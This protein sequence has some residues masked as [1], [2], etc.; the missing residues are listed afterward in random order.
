MGIRIRNNDDNV[1][2][3]F[4]TNILDLVD[5]PHRPVGV[6]NVD[7][8]HVEANTTE[9][10]CKT[11]IIEE[12]DALL[13]C[14]WSVSAFYFILFYFIFRYGIPVNLNARPRGY[15]TCSVEPGTLA[16]L[17]DNLHHH[18][19][20]VRLVACQQGIVT[21]SPLKPT[22]R[23][24]QHRHPLPHPHPLPPKKNITGKLCTGCF[25][26]KL[27]RHRIYTINFNKKNEY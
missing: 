20:T 7:G 18:P 13:T 12:L 10:Q 26:F 6:G 22:Q 14:S 3:A 1:A 16:E 19:L 11:R 17:L 21:H 27:Q 4:L 24:V 9:K 15:N 25:P 2:L 23:S 8:G 5:T